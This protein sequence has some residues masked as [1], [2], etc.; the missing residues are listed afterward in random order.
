MISHPPPSAP[1][2][3]HA[4]RRNLL[5]HIFV[6]PEPLF[7]RL[8][9]DSL[10]WKC[11]VFSLVG[12]TQILPKQRVIQMSPSVEFQRRLKRD[13]GGYVS[14]GEGVVDFLEGDI[15]IGDVGVVM[16]GVVEFHGFRRDDGCGGTRRDYSVDGVSRKGRAFRFEA[17]IGERAREETLDGRRNQQHTKTTDRRTRRKSHVAGRRSRRAN[18]ARGVCPP[19]EPRRDMPRPI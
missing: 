11:R 5:L 9:Q 6:T 3:S 8:L 12:G 16:F 4:Q 15:E 14:G 2:H 18:R 10:G 13:E 19:M 1:L 7:H 17:S